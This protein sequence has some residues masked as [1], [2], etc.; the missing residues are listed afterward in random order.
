[1]PLT[2][3]SIAAFAVLGAWA[4]YGQTLLL[5]SLCGRAFPW[6]TLSINVLG[7]FLMGFL[8]FATLDRVSLSP[9]LRAGLLTG[10]LGA[11]TTFSTFSLETVNL[12]ENGETLRA[13]L[14]I[15]ASV[16]LSLAAALF[17]A[18]LSRNLGA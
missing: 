14:Y 1:M 7:S 4:R 6:A 3:L 15:C 5:Q 17:G 13:L 11:Y 12:F 8:F 2:L 10:G 16:F 9:E 18:Y